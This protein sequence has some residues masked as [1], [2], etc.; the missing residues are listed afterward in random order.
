[1]NNLSTELREKLIKN[2]ASMVGFADFRR[3]LLMSVI[4]CLAVYP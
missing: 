2:G 4:T 3:L 1:M